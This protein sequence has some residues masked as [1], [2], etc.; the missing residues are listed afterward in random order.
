MSVKI[1][2]MT[3]PG[4]PLEGL[5]PL[6]MFHRRTLNRGKI[7]GDFPDWLSATLGIR[8]RYLPYKMQDRYSRKRL[9][10]K[11]KTIVMENE[12]LKATFWPEN[13]GKLYSLIDKVQNRELLMCNCVYQPGNLAIRNAWHSGGI[14]FNFGNIGHHYFTCDNL[15]VAL[16]KDDQ[17]QE[18]VRM[19]EFERA[20]STLYQMDFHLPQGS[21]VLYSHVKIFNPNKTDTTTYWWTNIAIPEDGNTRVLSNTNKVLVLGEYLSYEELPH[22]SPFGDA[23]LSYPHN[24]TRGYDHFY[25]TPADAK[26]AWEAG[27]D[28]KGN[29]FFDRSTAPLLYHKMFC[30]GNHSAAQ[31]WQ[32]HLS[33]PGKGNYIEIQA[34]ITHSQV[35]D[36]IFPANGTMEWTQCYGGAVLDRE[37]LHQ[38]DMNKAADYIEHYLDTVVS[39]EHLLAVNEYFAGLANME[40]READLI[41]LG[42]GWGALEEMRIAREGDIPF[43]KSMCFPRATI[44]EQQYP[45]YALLTQGQLPDEDPNVIP[46]SW[47]VPKKWLHILEDSIGAMGET[48]Y[49]QLHYGVMLYENLDDEHI[50]SVACNWPEYP[51]YRQMAKEAFLRSVE[52]EPSVWAYRCLSCI[53]QEEEEWILAEYYYDKAIELNA[54]SLDFAFAAEYMIL[55]NGREKYEKAWAFYQTLPDHIRNIDRMLLCA[56]ATAI[57]LRKLDFVEPLFHREYA[58]IKEGETSLTDIWFEYNALLLAKKRGLD[59]NLSPELLQQLK[60]EAW[61]TCP[62]PMGIDFRMSISKKEG[63]RAENKS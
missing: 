58:G 37:Q 11:M 35:H 12:F 62:P 38:K 63:Y 29:V 19:Y 43:P 23:E 32:D 55:L 33:E 10:M 48:W 21:P 5:N 22:L 42:S 6:P 52:L 39:E 41:H 1:D 56:A 40:V 18:F 47:M 31:Q 53:A 60:D 4:A 13:G 3:I 49:N 28:D 34:G 14:E 57:K 7:K 36:M 16:L 51:K 59:N 27:A 20:K 50:A 30:W 45:W 8:D 61:D 26:T 54:A 9:P 25:Q 46:P 24:A 15:F 17:G 44:G 2:V